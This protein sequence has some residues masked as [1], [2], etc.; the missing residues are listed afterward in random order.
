MAVAIGPTMSD[1]SISSTVLHKSEISPTCRINSVI[2]YYLSTELYGISEQLRNYS[3]FS[4]GSM[5]QQR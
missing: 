2:K 1:E 4:N 3:K 5:V